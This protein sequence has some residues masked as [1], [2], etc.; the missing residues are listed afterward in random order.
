MSDQRPGDTRSIPALVPGRRSSREAGFTLI[1]AVIVFVLVG[2]LSA[3]AFPKLTGASAKNNVRS[4]RGHAISLYAKARAAAI[5]TSRSTTLNF[6]GSRAWIT[7]TPRIVALAG[8]TRDTIGQVENLTSIYGVT[9]TFNPTGTLTIDPR[10]MGSS[11]V[12]TVWMTRN[13]FTDSMVVSGF[14]RVI[15]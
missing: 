12:T 13:G 10:G 8:S 9:L 4:A 11:T 2:I 7:A 14:G 1:E 5:E 3:L 15:K 6:T